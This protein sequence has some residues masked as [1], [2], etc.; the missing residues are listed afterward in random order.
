MSLNF[1]NGV[2]N[3]RQTPGIIANIFANQPGASDVANG[4]LFIATD[5]GAIYRSDGASWIGI[6]GGSAPDLQTVLTAGNTSSLGFQLFVSGAAPNAFTLHDPGTST[7]A[8]YSNP[9]FIQIIGYGT[10]TLNFTSNSFIRNDVGYQIEI[11]SLPGGDKFVLGFDSLTRQNSTGS[12]FARLNYS[13]TNIQ[14]SN[15][16][17]IIGLNIDF[18]N[19]VYSVGDYFAAASSTFL[20]I[21]DLNQRLFCS[22]NLRSTTAGGVSGQHLKIRVGTTDYK[23]QLLNP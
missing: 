5:T 12:Q 19:R 3:I 2:T 20:G 14:T 1:N 17:G 13:K 6:G 18:A 16:V 9:D 7:W 11:Q 22:L 8:N 10:P 21:D 23:I 15:N 4:T